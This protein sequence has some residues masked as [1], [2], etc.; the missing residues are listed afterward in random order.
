MLSGTGSDGTRRD[1]IG[2]DGMGSDGTGR[3]GIGLASYQLGRA[4]NRNFC[5]RLSDCQRVVIGRGDAVSAELRA[6]LIG[7]QLRPWKEDG[8]SRSDSA[9]VDQYRR[10]SSRRLSSKSA[11]TRDVS[12]ASGDALF[13]GREH[14]A[15][16]TTSRPKHSQHRAPQHGECLAVA[17]VPNVRMEAASS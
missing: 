11:S 3:D 16:S 9:P 6:E 13:G 7:H 8:V 17:D 4:S 2:R 1:G 12:A 5:G 10:R 15:E 14:N